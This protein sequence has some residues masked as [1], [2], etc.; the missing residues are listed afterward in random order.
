MSLEF[1]DYKK[2]SVAKLFL[3]IL[4]SLVCIFNLGLCDVNM[5]ASRKAHFKYTQTTITSLFLG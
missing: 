5:M 3:K 1:K 2:E 4:F